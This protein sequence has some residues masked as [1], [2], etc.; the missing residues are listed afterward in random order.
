MVAAIL[1][2]V[3]VK[4]AEG[5]GVGAL[6]KDNK[7][8]CARREALVL[9]GG[10]SA[11]H[12]HHHPCPELTPLFS[13]SQGFDFKLRFTGCPKVG[14]GRRV[15]ALIPGGVLWPQLPDLCPEAG[16]QHLCPAGPVNMAPPEKE[17]VSP[18]VV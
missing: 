6:D 12:R 13:T 7:Q 16:I 5:K 15:F 1:L 2:R 3:K 10:S 4:Y 14:W 11:A 9:R 17:A 8:R 18:T